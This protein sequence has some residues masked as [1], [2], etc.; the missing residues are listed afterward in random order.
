[1]PLP[2]YPCIAENNIIEGGL[3]FYLLLKYVKAIS[4]DASLRISMSFAPHLSLLEHNCLPKDLQMHAPPLILI[5]L[6][7]NTDVF[8]ADDA[9]CL[10]IQLES[11]DPGHRKY[12]KYWPS[13]ARK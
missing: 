8:N 4:K 12:Q 6:I 1:M 7:C 5:N 3:T 2:R 10:P 9:N 13:D 11:L